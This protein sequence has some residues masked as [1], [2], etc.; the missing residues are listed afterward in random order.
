MARVKRKSSSKVVEPIL[1]EVKVIEKNCWN[2]KQFYLCSLRKSL[3]EQIERH[4]TMFKDGADEIY[5]R[6][7][8]YD[9]IGRNCDYFEEKIS[10]TVNLVR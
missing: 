5:T 4:R 7:G 3:Q 9:I 1:E 8:I 10:G 2:C 6:D